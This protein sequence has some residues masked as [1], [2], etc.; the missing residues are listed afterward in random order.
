[1]PDAQTGKA[2]TRRRFQVAGYLS[3]LIATACVVR[4]GNF[5][6]ADI[7]VVKHKSIVIDCAAQ[8]LRDSVELA[9]VT[10]G[11]GFTNKF[12]IDTTCGKLLCKFITQLAR[13]DGSSARELGLILQPGQLRYRNSGKRTED[14]KHDDEFDQSEASLEAW[15]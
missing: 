13:N 14:G 12:C 2:L 6:T 3:D 15:V 5:H 10:D 8:G 4:D 9:S 7:T 1:M 11:A